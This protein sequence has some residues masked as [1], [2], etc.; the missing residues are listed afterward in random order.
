MEPQL[1]IYGAKACVYLKYADDIHSLAAKLSSGLQIPGFQI[2]AREEA[3]HDLLGMSEVLG[4]ELWLE[5]TD[6]VPTFQYSLRME[7]ELSTAEIF[8]GRMHDL[9]PWLARYI[10]SIC[11]LES[12]V[13]GTRVVFIA[14]KPEELNWK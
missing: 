14:G 6:K 9:S 10:S 5:Q 11:K 12:L 13:G 8:H 3:P 2:E 7:T 4:W 1:E